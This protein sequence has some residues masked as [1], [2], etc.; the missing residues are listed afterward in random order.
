MRCPLLWEPG[1]YRGRKVRNF[2]LVP[3][4]GREFLIRSQISVIMACES[5][6]MTNPEQSELVRGNY[7]Q[8]SFTQT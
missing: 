4:L 8:T 3:D 2:T 6:Y 7:V 5:V 1:W